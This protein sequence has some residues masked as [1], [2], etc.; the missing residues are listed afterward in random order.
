MAAVSGSSLSA[1]Q[2]R[3]LDIAVFGLK[4]LMGLDRFAGRVPW[5]GRRRIRSPCARGF[6]VS[7]EEEGVGEIW[8]VRG[9]VG[10]LRA[11]LVSWQPRSPPKRSSSNRCQI[12]VLGFC[13]CKTT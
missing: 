13:Q 6:A 7:L 12:Y 8:H 10:L 11:V 2:A 3:A 4:Q 9:V 1:C 5:L